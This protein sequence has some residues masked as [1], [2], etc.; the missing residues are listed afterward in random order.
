[1]YVLT[2]LYSDCYICYVYY[3]LWNEFYY[4]LLLQQCFILSCVVFSS[5]SFRNEMYFKTGSLYLFL[6]L[7]ELVC[8]VYESVKVLVFNLLYISAI[9]SFPSQDTI[10]F[11][12]HYLAESHIVISFQ[13]ISSRAVSVLF[14]NLGFWLEVCNLMQRIWL[15]L[16]LTEI[17]QTNQSKEDPVGSYN[18][19]FLSFFSIKWSGLFFLLG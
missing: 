13:L 6:N 3:S 11:D 4:V 7:N 8:Y 15:S 14:S 18:Q 17:L 19:I 2:V 1:M 5:L 9:Y 12:R 16:A 10:S